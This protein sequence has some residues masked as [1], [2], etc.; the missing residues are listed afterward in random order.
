MKAKL[1]ADKY[2]DKARNAITLVEAGEMSITIDAIDTID[3]IV[4]IIVIFYFVSCE[5]Y[6]I[7]L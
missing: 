6:S 1:G 7:L 4:I 5:N 2:T 3:T